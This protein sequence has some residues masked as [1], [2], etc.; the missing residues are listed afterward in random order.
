MRH[1]C[2]KSAFSL[3]R[4]FRFLKSLFDSLLGLD[5]PLF[6]LAY[7]LEQSGIT[8][9]KSSLIRKCLQ[10]LTILFGV[11]AIAILICCQHPKHFLVPDALLSMG[12]CHLKQKNSVQAR[13]AFQS[14]VDQYPESTQVY[15]ARNLLAT[16]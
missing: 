14:L 15:K 9:G 4:Q 11:R 12:Q 10:E 3:I 5:S 8:N 7:I 6:G 2:Q 16:L 1:A 13:K